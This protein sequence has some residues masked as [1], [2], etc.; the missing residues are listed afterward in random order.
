[1][2]EGIMKKRLKELGKEGIMVRSAGTRTI[3]GFSPTAHTAEVLKD[4]G[5]ELDNFK[6][7]AI[8]KDIIERSDLILV[9]E[10]MHKDEVLKLVPEA[11]SKTFL[12]REYG[13]TQGRGADAIAGEIPDPIGGAV[14]E[15]RTCLNLIKEDIER[16][17]K[18]L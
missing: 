15:Y 6:S 7:T 1:M 13:R 17:V 2:A 9:M 16:I 10:A 8:N 4:E 12:L 14:S 18:I 11:A 3:N 5:A